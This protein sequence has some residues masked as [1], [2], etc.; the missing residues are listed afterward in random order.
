[1]IDEKDGYFI[2]DWK[3]KNF[4]KTLF[5]V[6]GHSGERALQAAELNEV[7]DRIIQNRKTLA[8]SIFTE[9]DVVQGTVEYNEN[10]IHIS[11]DCLIYAGGAIRPMPGPPE[12]IPIDGGESCVIGL[13][14]V[15]EVADGELAADP[16]ENN[17]CPGAMRLVVYYK[18][19]I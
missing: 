4:E 9:G 7:E 15:E 12:G 8:D 11:E 18:Y 14:R 5:I 6:S 1:M 16:Y 19:T 3:K 2:H 10:R 13:T 17:K